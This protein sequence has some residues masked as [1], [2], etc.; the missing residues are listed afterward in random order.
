MKNHFWK[1]SD[2]H[3]LRLSNLSRG[4]GCSILYYQDSERTVHLEA[5]LY[6]VLK[7]VSTLGVR[8]IL[9]FSHSTLYVDLVSTLGVRLILGFSH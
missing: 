1:G 3:S 8:L 5:A 6:P 9:G 7:P 4:C 2:N